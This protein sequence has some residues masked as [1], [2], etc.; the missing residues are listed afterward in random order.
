MVFHKPW[1]DSYLIIRWPSK[2][3]SDWVTAQ[4]AMLDV[5]K[6]DVKEELS[7]MTDPALLDA[8]DARCKEMLKEKVEEKVEE[9]VVE[10]AVEVEKIVEAGSKLCAKRRIDFHSAMEVKMDRLERVKSITTGS[11]ALDQ[12]LGGG[13][14]ETGSITMVYGENRCGKSQL[15]AHAAHCVDVLAPHRAPA[16]HQGTLLCACETMRACARASRTPD[17]RAQRD[18]GVRQLLHA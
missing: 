6:S 3:V 7:A 11:K 5:L 17:A 12:I 15:C 18:D 10:K 9:K 8:V 1:Y 2:A 4:L 16:L 14:V 13:G